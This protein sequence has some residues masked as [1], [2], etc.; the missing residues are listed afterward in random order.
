VAEL[1]GRRRDR[2]SRVVKGQ[3]TGASCRRRL[4]G[5]SARDGAAYD[6]LWRA[7]DARVLAVPWRQRGDDVLVYGAGDDQW[8][9]LARSWHGVECARARGGEG[10]DYGVQARRCTAASRVV[11]VHALACPCVVVTMRS[12]A[13]RFPLDLGSCQACLVRS[14][15]STGHGDKAWSEW[16]RKRTWW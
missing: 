2:R 4:G 15:R 6:A 16:E 11:L 5:A 8:R 9:C 7:G 14:R 1:A 13:C 10:K 3:V 12:R